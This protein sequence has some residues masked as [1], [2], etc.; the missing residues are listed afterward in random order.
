M[1]D[2]ARQRGT[3]VEVNRLFFNA[4]ARAKFLK[5]VSAETRAVS[6]T[7]TTLALAHPAVALGLVSDGRTLL[8]LPRGDTVPERLARMWGDEA[9]ES[10]IEIS[11]AEAGWA[12]RGWIQRPDAVRPGMRRS[13]LFVNGRP[14]RDA[15]LIK[16]LDRGYRT[17][18]VEG[19]RPWAVLYLEAPRGGVDVNVHPAKAEVRFRDAGWVERWLEDAVREGLS[20]EV[21]SARMGA[22]GRAPIRARAPLMPPLTRRARQ[23]PRAGREAPVPS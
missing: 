23:R 13:H 18:V 21:S 11:T 6:E 9:A 14:F 3:T 20:N 8:D 22:A 17:T 1:T 15:R 5:A 4:P 2:H 12:L 16:A 19:Y 7:L 10:L